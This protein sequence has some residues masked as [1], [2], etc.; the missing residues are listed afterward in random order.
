MD[1]FYIQ[2]NNYQIYYFANIYVMLIFRQLATT[3]YINNATY[4]LETNIDI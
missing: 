3:L 2:Y 1:F 4:I